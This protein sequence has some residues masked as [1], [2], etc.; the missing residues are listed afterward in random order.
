M[1][2][3]KIITYYPKD[4]KQDK[5]FLRN[6]KSFFWDFLNKGYIAAKLGSFN[7]CID[8]NALYK[9]ASCIRIGTINDELIA[10]AV[11]TDYQEGHK[12][13]GYTVTTNENLRELGKQCL[14]DIIK[15]DI[16]AENEYY[17]TMCSGS[18]ERL[19]DKF[20]G[21]KIPN[22]FSSIYL[23]KKGKQSVIKQ[24]LPDGFSFIIKDRF[25]NEHK[26][27]IFGYNSPETF[28]KIKTYIEKSINNDTES[29]NEYINNIK[30][31]VL[32]EDNI[33]IIYET[34]QSHIQKL[35]IYIEVTCEYGWYDLPVS[36]IRKLNKI[37]NEAEIFINTYKY[38]SYSGFKTLKHNLETC[39]DLLKN[40]I[41]PLKM[42]IK[43]N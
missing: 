40:D 20:G 4:Y 41:Q 31:K 6:N 13:V 42:N 43:M 23:D 36:C 35:A 27:V 19:W 28:N 1:N 37:I 34:M 10:L 30:Y 9:N 14:Y 2:N 12:A 7:S 22:I 29:I 17:W 26:K 3:Y 8:E 15:M 24:L 39:K 16:D 18:I 25:N 33:D 5:D 21:T 11:Y 32:N 38:L